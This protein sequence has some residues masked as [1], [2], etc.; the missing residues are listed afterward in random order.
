MTTPNY[1]RQRTRFD[2]ERFFTS[3]EDRPSIVSS[4]PYQD[5][6]ARVLAAFTADAHPALWRALEVVECLQA[7]AVDQPS[8]DDRRPGK[9]LD[10]G[11]LDSLSRDWC[12]TTDLPDI[13]REVEALVHRSF[14]GLSGS[15]RALLAT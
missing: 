13:V 15:Y 4:L 7:Y 1:Y 12:Q 6:H 5:L 9:T 10:L 8:G 11:Y 2:P 3:S 14:D